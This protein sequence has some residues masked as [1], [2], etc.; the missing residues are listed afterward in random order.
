MGL[1]FSLRQ[2]LM[3]QRA[4]QSAAGDEGKFAGQHVG[5]ETQLGDVFSH[6]SGAMPESYPQVA[7]PEWQ[8]PTPRDSQVYHCRDR[9]RKTIAYIV[10]RFE[11]AEL[12]VSCSDNPSHKNKKPPKH[13]SNLFFQSKLIAE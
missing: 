13:K 7:A 10:S 3:A 9:G 12:C 4:A 1:F 5:E 6:F 2:Q 8:S 11:G